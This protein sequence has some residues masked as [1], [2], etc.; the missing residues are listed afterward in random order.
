MSG[1]PQTYAP[2]EVTVIFGG[3]IITGFGDEIVSTKRN[4]MLFSQTVG[5]DGESTHVKNANRS[6]EVKIT[7]KQTS[8]GNATLGAIVQKDE[9]DGDQIK[10][11]MIK[12]NNGHVIAAGKGRLAGYPEAVDRGKD[13]KDQV[14]TIICPEIEYTFA[15]QPTAA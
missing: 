12:D 3:N 13:V 7:L 11:L 2:G 5:A 4:E 15:A 10:S 9:I 1:T 8:A 6:G 14:W